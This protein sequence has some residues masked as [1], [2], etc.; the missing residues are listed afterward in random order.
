MA[1]IMMKYRVES[2]KGS[3]VVSENILESTFGALNIMYDRRLFF[4]FL[5]KSNTIFVGLEALF[6]VV[7]LK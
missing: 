7:S 4:C 5:S 3:I 1:R 2:G 6:E